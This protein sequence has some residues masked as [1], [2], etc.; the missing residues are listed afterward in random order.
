MDLQEAVT[1]GQQSVT[2]LSQVQTDPLGDDGGEVDCSQEVSGKFVVASCNAPEI[3]ESAET[4]LD[5]I[6][7]FVDA[8]AEALEGHRWICLE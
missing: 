1:A 8:F 2:L 7:P 3:L 6:A 5:N 4:A